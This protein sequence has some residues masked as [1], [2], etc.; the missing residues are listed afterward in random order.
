VSGRHGGPLRVALLHHHP[1]PA[2]VLA[3]EDALRSAGHRPGL[4]APRP[5][6]PVERVLRFRGFATPLSHVPLALAA[7]ARGRFDV[8][9]AFAPQDAAAALSWRQR[10]GVPVVFTPAVP[11]DRANVAD[12]RLTL[13]LLEHALDRADAITAPTEAVRE[14]LER[15][16]AIDAPVL[17]PGD[18]TG[19]EHLYQ[20]LLARP[21]AD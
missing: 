13:R 2:C 6:R 10:S 19:H 1:P 20:V 18:A 7:Y 9:H 5:V 4:V 14:A 11:P 17:D 21:A 16:L 3:L 15:W 8:A 12:S